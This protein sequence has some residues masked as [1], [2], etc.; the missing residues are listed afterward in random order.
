MDAVVSEVKSF[1]KHSSLKP[2]PS[3]LT[4]IHATA[5][6]VHNHPLSR[7][8]HSSRSSLHHLADQSSSG[9][10]SDSPMAADLHPFVHLPGS[11][12]RSSPARSSQR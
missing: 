9:S 3:R 8:R 6:S 1:T 11:T 10:G 2:T 5:A 4:D 12:L 7:S